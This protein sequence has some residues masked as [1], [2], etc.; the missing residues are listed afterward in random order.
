MVAIARAGVNFTDPR[1]FMRSLAAASALTIFDSTT[2]G[3]TGDSQP[4]FTQLA[5]QGVAD[6]TNWT[7]ATYKT[8]L[9]VS[10]GIGVVFN[11]IGPT[12]LAGT[13]TT[14]FEVTVDGTLTEVAVVATT[15]GQRAVLGPTQSNVAF[16][17]ASAWL[18]GATSIDAAKDTQLLVT[19]NIAPP[20][21]LRTFGSPALIF[22]TSLLIR[23]KSSENNSTTAAV[24]RQ[25]GVSYMS[26]S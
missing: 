26:M 22:R 25:S 9:S 1:E 5:T 17:T 15:T 3:Q 8:I 13:P 21:A 14:T 2:T 6:D 16:T 7:A 4:F 10:S 24:Q 18:Q 12:G 20:R 11:L 23:M 19:P